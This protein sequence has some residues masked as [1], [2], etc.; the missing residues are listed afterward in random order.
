MSGAETLLTE[1]LVGK[2]PYRICDLK[3]GGKELMVL[4]I[5]GEK[6]GDV[7]EALRRL[8]VNEPEQNRRERLLEA[9]KKFI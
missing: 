3:I 2:E 8:V 5:K 7:L 4:G 6:I 9:T 1:I